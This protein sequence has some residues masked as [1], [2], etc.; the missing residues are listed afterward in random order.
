MIAIIDSPME[1][2]ME[3]G[4]HRDRKGL[5]FTNVWFTG[6]ARSDKKMETKT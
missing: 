6:N 1:N 2:D 3:T 4:L 5:V